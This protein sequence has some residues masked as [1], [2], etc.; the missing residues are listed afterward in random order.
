M[1]NT[2]LEGD[3]SPVEIRG[4]NEKSM[5][6]Y[7]DYAVIAIDESHKVIAVGKA[8]Y[9][10]IDGVESSGMSEISVYSTF[11]R[12]VVADF[13]GTVTVLKSIFKEIVSGIKYKIF[14]PTVAVCIPF[15]LTSVELKA[16]Q[17][18]FYVAGAKKVT[19]MQLEF[20]DNKRQ[21]AKS[22]S[23]VIGIVPNKL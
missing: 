13:F 11:K 8:A 1:G 10:Y 19:I 12:N 17:D 14:K 4:Y 15:E 5:Q 7:S 6:T 3:F 20:E 21:L 18:V 9:Q 16:F 22:Y 2:R 23:I